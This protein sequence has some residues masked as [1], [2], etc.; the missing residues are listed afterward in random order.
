MI[1]IAQSLPDLP[2]DPDLARVVW[3]AGQFWVGVLAVLIGLLAGVWVMAAKFGKLDLT[4][5]N[6]GDR[7]HELA[8]KVDRL[9][10]HSTRIGSLE[11]WRFAVDDWMRKRKVQN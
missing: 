4:L 7:V 11:Q 3:T 5:N 8:T 2:S 10:D 9:A 6:L 1:A